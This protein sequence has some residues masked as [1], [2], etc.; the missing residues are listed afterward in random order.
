LP[1]KQSAFRLEEFCSHTRRPALPVFKE[2]GRQ[3]EPFCAC[4]HLLKKIYAK[5]NPAEKQFMVSRLV[6]SFG[7]V[8]ASRHYP[9]RPKCGGSHVPCG[10]M[11]G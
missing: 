1:T 8:T 6:G 5:I 11:T 9:A 4:G 7:T 3:H 2:G 10:M